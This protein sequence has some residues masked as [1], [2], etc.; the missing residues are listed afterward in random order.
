[1]S[2]YNSDN[3]D[4]LVHEIEALQKKGLY[5]Q[6]YKSI[7]VYEKNGGRDSQIL[8]KKIEIEERSYMLYVKVNKYILYMILLSVLIVNL[9]LIP[10]NP[11]YVPTLTVIALVW[12]F[13]NYVINCR[14]KKFYL[15]VMRFIYS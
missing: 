1:M 14:V 10:S 4:E 15:K 5:R 9:D 3:S 12:Y 13:L 7:L 11:N 6:I 2:Q 8:N